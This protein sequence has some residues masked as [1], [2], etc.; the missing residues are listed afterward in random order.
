MKKKDVSKKI[1]AEP[2]IY[3]FK[4]KRVK[5][6]LYVGKA[7]SLSD[8]VKSYFNKDVVES[9]GPR[10]VQMVEEADSVE[11]VKTDSV[12]EAL[13]LE[14]E[15]IK[16]FK[17]P[18]NVKEKDDKSYNYVA[19]TKEDYPRVVLVRGKELRESHEQYK[20]T[21]GPF[22]R[23]GE[24]KEAMRIVRKIFPWRDK[25]EVDQKKP[26]FNAQIGLCPGVCMGEIS[27]KEY[28]ELVKNISLFFTGKKKEVL[29]N[30]KQEMKGYVS[31]KEFEKAAIIRNRIFSLEHIHDVALLKKDGRTHDRTNI[32]LRIESYDI[33][34]MAGSDVVGVMAVMEGGNLA[35]QEY[36]KFKIKSG[37]G[38]DDTGNLREVLDRRFRHDE[39]QKPNILVIDGGT[40]QVNVAK[41]VL[42]ELNYKIPV[43]GVVKDARHKATKLLGLKS[44]ITKHKDDIVA[45][46]ADTHRYAIAY[47]KQKRAKSFL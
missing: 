18:Y 36:R 43:V 16:K 35:K 8:R 23:G 44:I 6:P 26:C 32:G 37:K 7:T 17:P 38:I 47:H 10:I 4:K 41:D 34:H 42:E 9:R 31:K 11:V 1:P 22:T 19:I 40:A 14:S 25:C 30:L 39:W 24:L 46:N 3:L 15:F 12:L 45:L 2:G 13:L 20:K 33:A 5:T 27:K 28:S 21:F 29:K